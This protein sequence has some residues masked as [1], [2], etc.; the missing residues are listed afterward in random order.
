[1]SF[2]NSPGQISLVNDGSLVKKLIIENEPIM[3]ENKKGR[4][5]WP[6]NAFSPKGIVTVSVSIVT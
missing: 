3:D 6:F 4:V 5:I 1:M 2:P